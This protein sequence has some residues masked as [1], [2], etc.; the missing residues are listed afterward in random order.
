MNYWFGHQAVL[1]AFS[2]PKKK[3]V[4]LIDPGWGSCFFLITGRRTWEKGAIAWLLVV[5]AKKRWNKSIHLTHMIKGLKK[6][7]HVPCPA[8]VHKIT[9]DN[10]FV[11]STLTKKR[12]PFW[13][14]IK[15][16]VTALDCGILDADLRNCSYTTLVT[17]IFFREGIPCLYICLAP[18]IYSAFVNYSDPLNFDTFCYVTAL[19]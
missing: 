15:S 13:N 7:R 12:L 16:A 18:M 19:L 4:K 3:H 9:G 14:C 1:V 8:A 5:L 2:G 17:A 10:C 6:R 11:C